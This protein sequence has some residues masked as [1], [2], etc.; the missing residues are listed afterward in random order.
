MLACLICVKLDELNE[1]QLCLLSLPVGDLGLCTDNSLT[2]TEV[3]QINKSD[4]GSISE[5]KDVQDT[6]TKNGTPAK[7]GARQFKGLGR[8]T[9]TALQVM[10]I[11]RG[12]MTTR[13]F[14]YFPFLL[15]LQS[16]LTTV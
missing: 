15:P 9:F 7:E 4:T 3:D 10:L 13:F 6:P 14:C 11:E 2:S 1:D 5:T 8:D 12:L 16:K